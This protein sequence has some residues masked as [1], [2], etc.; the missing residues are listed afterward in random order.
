M[1]TGVQTGVGQAKG[2]C[3]PAA[4]RA[5]AYRQYST[6][7]VDAEGKAKANQSG[8]WF[9]EFVPPWQWRRGC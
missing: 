9:G 2:V 8:T 3:Q 6:D 5:L 1:E 7:Y 4:K